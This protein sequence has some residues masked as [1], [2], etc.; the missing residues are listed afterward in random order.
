MSGPLAGVRVVELGGIGP[1][2]FAG[3][4]LAD[5]GAD[6]VRIERP[7]AAGS[8]VSMTRGKRLVEVDLRSTAGVAQVLDLAAEAAILIEGFRPGVAERLGLGPADCQARNPAL[9]YGRMTGWGQSGPW[10]ST[11][12]HDINYI[13]LTGAL[14]AIG[15]AGGPP[16]IPLCLVGDLGGGAMFLVTGVLAALHEAT[17]T[18]VGRVV[19]AAIV[20]GATAL[21]LPI[22]E[23]AA[24]G[25]WVDERGANMLDSG[26]PWYDV[27][28][29]A[30]G[31]W[32]SVGALE[33]KFY[34]AFIALLG[35]STV[36][37]DRTDPASW[38]GLR[39]RIAA[40]FATADREHWEK[41]FDGTDACV[42]PVL[43]LAEAPHHPHMAARKNLVGGVAAPAP[44]FAG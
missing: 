36:E 3:L 1:G 32:M 18:G 15:R 10:S 23:M 13:G 27:Y 25:H 38:P 16:S 9:V 33:D 4:Q 39:E 12:G 19:D 42:A 28:E 26:R 35:L 2:P 30:D 11:A 8:P 24:G 40:R 21:M 31:R 34:A 6:V 29:T 7:D 17:R 14:H 43:S 37:S 22:H 41:V 5:M 20:D 44:R